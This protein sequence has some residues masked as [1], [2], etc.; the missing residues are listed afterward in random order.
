MRAATLG[1]EGLWNPRYGTRGGAPFDGHCLPKDA[2][3][4]LRYADSMGFGDLMPILRAAIQVNGEISAEAGG[5]AVGAPAGGGQQ[6]SI[7]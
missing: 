6:E 2:T 4:F 3:G 1:A 5:D 7:L